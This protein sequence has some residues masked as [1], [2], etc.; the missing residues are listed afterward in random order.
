MLMDFALNETAKMEILRTNAWGNHL[1]NLQNL[2]E[3]ITIS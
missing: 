1:K 3:I 2:V